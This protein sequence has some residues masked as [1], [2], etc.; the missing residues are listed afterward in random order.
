MNDQM[1]HDSRESAIESLNVAEEFMGE[2]QY[3]LCLADSDLCDRA[4]D[5]G[6]EINALV[7]ELASRMLDDEME[8]EE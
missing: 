5:I 7:S 2:A 1:I 6:A 3:G 4:K 8:G